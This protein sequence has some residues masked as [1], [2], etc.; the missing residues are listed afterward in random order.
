MLDQDGLYLLILAQVGTFSSYLWEL[1][2]P[3]DWPIEL[4]IL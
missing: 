4:R 2:M 3:C 1:T